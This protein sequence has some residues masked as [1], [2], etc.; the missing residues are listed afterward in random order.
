[1]IHQI[2]ILKKKKTT[3]I[4]NIQRDVTSYPNPQWNEKD[5]NICVVAKILAPVV[6]PDKPMIMAHYMAERTFHMALRWPI[7]WP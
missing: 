2:P 7:S 4:W 5:I 1:M 3:N 6:F